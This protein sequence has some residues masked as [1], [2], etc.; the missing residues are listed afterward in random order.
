MILIGV[1][2]SMP[3]TGK[4]DEQYRDL[5]AHECLTISPNV[6]TAYPRATGAGDSNDAIARSWQSSNDEVAHES[7]SRVTTRTGRFAGPSILVA[8]GPITKLH[9][10]FDA[11]AEIAFALLLD[12]LPRPTKI[13]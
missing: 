5:F 6:L 9:L 3:T 1:S 12:E 4:V 13:C 2:A 7:L 10:K 8:S 11:N